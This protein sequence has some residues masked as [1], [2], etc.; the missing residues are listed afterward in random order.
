M[1]LAHIR[2]YVNTNKAKLMVVFVEYFFVGVLA[3]I[4]RMVT[5]Y[6]AQIVNNWDMN[7]I[8]RHDFPNYIAIYL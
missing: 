5:T 8:K 6:L 2:I 7:D 1:P 4:K 3:V